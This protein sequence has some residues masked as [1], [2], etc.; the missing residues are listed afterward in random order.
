MKK[1]FLTY[2]AK[3]L[4]EK[5]RFYM[6]MYFIDLVTR[7]KDKLTINTK[8]ATAIKVLYVDIFWL[9]GEIRCKCLIYLKNISSYP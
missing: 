3:K 1:N 2:L 8:N 4:G 6:R 5:V 9:C 7:K